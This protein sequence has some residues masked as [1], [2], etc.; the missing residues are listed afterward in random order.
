MYETGRAARW[1]A[2]SQQPSSMPQ[3]IHSADLPWMLTICLSAGS[4]AVPATT[5]PGSQDLF[6]RVSGGVVGFALKAVAASNGTKWA[7]VRDELSKAPTL[8][9]GESDVL[10]LWS[11]KIAAEVR[12]ALCDQAFDTFGPGQ[13][14][15][16]SD[17]RLALHAND[18]S[19]S[20]TAAKG[21]AAAAKGKVARCPCRRREPLWHR[22]RRQVHCP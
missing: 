11:L 17:G 18:G 14:V 5:Q 2:L 22:L 9:A 13:W 3:V 19:S 16:G 20:T 7:D 4:L 10:V 8:P 15:L 1:Q 12:T 6:L 21:R